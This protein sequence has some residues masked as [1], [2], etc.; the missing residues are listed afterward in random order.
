MNAI[1]RMAPETGIF[2]ENVG[3][4]A[5][6]RLEPHAPIN[7]YDGYICPMDDPQ[8]WKR[9]ERLAALV[10]ENRIA[11]FERTEEYCR[12]RGETDPDRMVHVSTFLHLDGYFY[13][14]Y[15]ANT[16]AAAEDPRMQ[17]CRLAVYP[18]GR[19]QDMAVY[20][21]QSV[22]DTLDGRTI[23]AVYDT[24]LLYK[25]GDQLYLLWT[26]SAAGEYYRFYCIYDRA[27][28]TLS[29]IR[30]NRF[31]VGAVVND[32]SVTGIVHALSA[33][34][35][36]HKRMFADI[37]IMQKLTTRVENGEIWYYTGA[38][39]GYFN[40]IIRSRD[41]ITWD[42]VA[43]P[44]F[45]NL[46][47]WE[48]AVYVWG[49]RC[50]YFVRQVDC[51]QGFLTYYDLNTH[52]WAPPCLVRDAQ[53]RSDF[54]AYAGE[55]YLIHAPRDRNGFGILRVDREQ[56]KNSRPVAVA[57]MQSSCFYPFARVE[58]DTVYLSYTVDRRHIRLSRFPAAALLEGEEP[59]N[60]P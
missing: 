42:Y 49:D 10:Q 44:D 40:C 41:F 24:I 7:G 53:S 23:D 16:S 22:G 55:L 25:G 34:G 39:S 14:T 46:S 56:L 52:I 33:N 51:Q 2:T 6:E 35:L 11:D 30:P 4:Q 3:G 37:G 47:Q 26:A 54:I 29:A 19:P 45:I 31:R 1:G 18:E 28:H 60:E 15:Y 9:G 13:M 32:F 36:A 59:H 50:Y 21:V 58:E 48:N 17:E 43:K 8:A 20:T 57:D 12:R 5:P 27:A 38:Y